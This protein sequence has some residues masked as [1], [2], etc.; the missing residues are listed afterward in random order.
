MVKFVIPILF[1]GAIL[2]SVH[3]I[4][5]H[6]LIAD[7]R[8]DDRFWCVIEYKQPW[9]RTYT[10]SIDLLNTF[11]PFCINLIC[12]IVL[13]VSLST[14]RKRVVTKERYR[15]IIISQSR[16]HK[17]LLVGPFTIIITKLPL[18]I[19][20]LVIKCISEQWHIYLSLFAYCLSLMPLISTFLI[21]VLPSDSYMKKFKE[22]IQHFRRRMTNN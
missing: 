20:S 5:N 18:V 21:F 16:Q 13:I 4:F 11:I 1:I 22:Y 17:D 15:T 6:G 12:G 8:A 19:A 7:P 14:T 9:L 2:T 3:N 10:I